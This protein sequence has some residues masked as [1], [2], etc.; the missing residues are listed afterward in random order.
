MH[1]KD[2]LVMSR[3]ST[4]KR[5]LKTRAVLGSVYSFSWAD[6]GREEGIDPGLATV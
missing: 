1:V 6:K 3:Y 5:K 4:L 2:G